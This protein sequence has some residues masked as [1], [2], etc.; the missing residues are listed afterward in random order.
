MLTQCPECKTTFRLHVKQLKAAGGKVRC[1]RCDATFDALDNLFET[2]RVIGQTPLPPQEPTQ[3]PRPA[4]PQVTATPPPETEPTQP[5]PAPPNLE[6]GEEANAPPA[7][8]E[9]QPIPEEDSWQEDDKERITSIFDEPAAEPQEDALDAL[10]DELTSC[11]EPAESPIVEDELPPQTTEEPTSSVS[12][13]LLSA[14][15]DFIDDT[16]TGTPPSPL[17]ERLTEPEIAAAEELTIELVGEE[18]L[19]QVEPQAQPEESVSE[20]AVEELSI[21]LADEEPLPLDEPQAPPEE[22][23]IEPAAEELTVEL[24]DEEPTAQLS[25]S[26]LEEELTIETVELEPA[27]APEQDTNLDELNAFFEEV[28]PEAEESAPIELDAGAEPTISEQGVDT[29]FEVPQRDDMGDF[30]NEEPDIITEQILAETPAETPI[31]PLDE[32]LYEAVGTTEEP[33]S[34]VASSEEQLDTFFEQSEPLASREP[35]PDGPA[36]LAS[37]TPEEE[38]LLSA[39]EEMFDLFD[40]EPALPRQEEPMELPDEEALDEVQL[41]EEPEEPVAPPPAIDPLSTFSEEQLASIL[42]PTP[43]PIEGQIE[44]QPADPTPAQPVARTSKNKRL[45]DTRRNE[46]PPPPGPGT[47]RPVAA[48][49]SIPTELTQTERASSTSTILW[50]LGVVLMC[51]ALIL[52]YL[53]YFRLQLVDNPQLRPVLSAMCSVTG[54]ELPPQRDL[55]HIELTE[56]LMQFHPTYE[57]SLLI[58]ATIANSADFNQ[59]YPL[60]EVIMTDIEQQVVARR[61]FLPDQYL[62]NFS[63]GDSFAA[64]SEVPLMLEVLDPGNSAVGF[65]LRFH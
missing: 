44:E 57:E 43:D 52:Q 25:V 42:S 48:S 55:G 47:Q 15:F 33:E 26:P 24:A 61:H 60:L 54:C 27:L 63:S 62:S 10:I 58:T 11:A 64:H 38:K 3:Q 37:S 4:T 34:E 23:R 30:F 28:E 18:P 53:Y 46:V 59:P 31:E 45:P 8:P 36:E 50:G 35:L 16:A 49:Y 40:E 12:V 29:V 32:P 14:A 2:P 19:P 20:P 9:Q 13:E 17:E 6:A 1:S 39:Q 5:Q 41:P 22:P 65:E 56:H 21:E 51:A 7:A